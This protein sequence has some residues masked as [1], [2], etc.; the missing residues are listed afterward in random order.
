MKLRRRQFLRLAASAAIFGVMSAVPIAWSGDGAW[1][2]TVRTIKII[3]PVPAGG[4]Q[5]VESRL[6]ADEIGRTQGA[7]MVI[8][9]RPGA[10]TA[11]AAEAVSRA[12]PDGSTLLGNAPPFLINPLLRKQNYDPL[13]GFEPICYLVRS[14][15]V[16]VVNSASPYRTLV[17]LLKAARA[18]PG[19]LT[20]ASI[21][22][23]SAT[24]IA[25]EMLKR[26]ADVEMTFVPYPGMGPAVNALLGEHVTSAFGNYGDIV[27]QLKAGR[28][29]ALATGSRTRIESLPDLPTVAES[30]YR[31]YE[32]DIWYGLAAPARTPKDTLSRLAG[33][34]TAALQVPEVRG[35][36]VA[37]GLFPVGMCGA[38]FGAFLRRQY[39]GYSRAIREANIKAE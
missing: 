13:N 28:L 38:D 27:E 31:E 17:D 8:E 16:I 12:A 15:T 20:L 5:D 36:L 24:Q 22:P 3:V 19:A 34:F 35:K 29:R 32:A 30:G 11:I 1:S 7:T 14:P 4:S 33:W 21:G 6:L 26:A 10:G 25:F 2:Q 39:D 9:N 23:G 18:K 37:Q